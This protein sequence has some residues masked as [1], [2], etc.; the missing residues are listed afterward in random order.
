MG[1]IIPYKKEEPERW[2]QQ[3]EEAIQNVHDETLR[4]VINAVLNLNELEQTGE[5]KN[6]RRRLDYS[7]L[8]FETYLQHHTTW[9]LSDFRLLEEAVFEHLDELKRNGL[10]SVLTRLTKLKKRR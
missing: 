3:N 7:K 5:W 10:G 6:S 4:A 9:S 2:K 8:P 1:K